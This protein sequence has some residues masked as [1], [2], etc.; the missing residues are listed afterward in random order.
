MP[1]LAFYSTPLRDEARRIAV[2]VAKPGPDHACL[3]ET[4]SFLMRPREIGMAP[5]WQRQRFQCSHAQSHEE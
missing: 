4:N 2:N 5:F 1:I 3:S